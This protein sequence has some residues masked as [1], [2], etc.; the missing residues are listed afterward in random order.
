MTR[1]VMT[2][3]AILMVAALIAC[4]KPAPKPDARTGQPGH[5]AAQTAQKPV[6]RTGLW[7]IDP[8]D[9]ASVP[10]RPFMAG[11]ISD[12]STQAVWLVVRAV[13]TAGYWVQ[14]PAMV[15]P[16]SIWV[17]QPYVGLPNTPAGVEFEVRAFANP[18]A[19]L[20]SGTELNGWPEAQWTSNLVTFS[21][22]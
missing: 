15:R 2:S 19:E 21:R 14:P 7:I 18:K 9:G 13:N 12:Q 11:T 22:Q 20:K 3:T 8:T 1:I 16:D 6:I 17:A 4:G 10:E 5:P